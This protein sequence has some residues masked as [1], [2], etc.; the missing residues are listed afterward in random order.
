MSNHCPELKSI[1]MSNYTI[2][3]EDLPEGK[4]RRSRLVEAKDVNEK[5]HPPDILTYIPF[6]PVRGAIP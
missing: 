1:R 5:Q 3:A 6:S 2:L 4:V